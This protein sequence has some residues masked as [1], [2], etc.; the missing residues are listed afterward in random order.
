MAD[1]KIEFEVKATT[2][3]AEQAFAVLES[4]IGKAGNTIAGLKERASGLRTALEQ[5]AIG[6][7]AFKRLSAETRKAETEL[8]KYTSGVGRNKSALDSLKS[9]ALTLGVAFGAQ[10]ILSFAKHALTA[11]ADLKVLKSSFKGTAET[12]AL[13]KKATA[14]NLGEMSLLKLSNY[15]S[16]L[17]LTLEQQAIAFSLAE[18]S[19]DK[20]GTSIEEGFGKFVGASEGMGKALK[21]IGISQADYD[22]AVK[23]VLKSTG[24]RIEQLDLESQKQVRVDAIIKASGLTLDD[25]NKKIKD[26]ADTIKSASV[27]WE[28]LTVA[29]GQLLNSPVMM[30][31]FELTA[32]AAKGWSI[33]LGGGSGDNYAIAGAQARKLDYYNRM[34]DK[35]KE[36]LS[37]RWDILAADKAINDE[38]LKHVTWKEEGDQIRLANRFLEERLNVL[39]NMDLYLA[40][41][42]VK[43]GKDP[44]KLSA[45][46]ILRQ[47]QLT[48]KLNALKRAEFIITNDALSQGSK[49]ITDQ[50]TK[51]RLLAEE[52]R[53]RIA[54]T[55]IPDALAEGS[56]WMDLQYGGKKPSFEDEFKKLTTEEKYK[57]T[58][59]E[60]QNLGNALG[61][62]FGNAGDTFIGKMQEALS[63]INAVYQVVVAI[64]TLMTILKL[65][66]TA[67][68]IAA[69]PSTGGASLIPIVT[70]RMD[71]N[72]KGGQGLSGSPSQMIIPIYIGQEKIQTIIIDT[73][74]QAQR[75][76][77]L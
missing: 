4:R 6:S 23:E 22:K 36:E 26:N 14:D 48:E 61:T 9:A 7:D 27:A 73:T 45:E 11:A 24:Y 58:F 51:N 34:K 65:I 15:A 55:G 32:M 38:R 75:L 77:Y 3:Q 21:G 10:Q 57:R 2:A 76:R 50:E 1:K 12:M 62:I 33:I 54:R 35:T 63:V 18:D 30:K 37:L 31:F 46:E 17:N 64:Q 69:A 40:G 70:P 42:K 39:K 72:Q 71:F 16:D 66:K 53:W 47:S 49:W 56:K 41:S 59:S 25:V 20:Y 28:E 5:S 52:Y 67:A 68:A 60:F 13:F 43:G 74:K 8:A 19:A 44:L 29:V